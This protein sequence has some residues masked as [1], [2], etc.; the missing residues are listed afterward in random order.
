MRILAG[1]GLYEFRMAFGV[2]AGMPGLCLS[3]VQV[4]VDDYGFRKAEAP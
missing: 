2:C 3:S 1:S 4:H